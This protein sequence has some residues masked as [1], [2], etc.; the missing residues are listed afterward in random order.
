MIGE[1]GNRMIYIYISCC[2]FFF[3]LMKMAKKKPKLFCGGGGGD[4]RV[5]ELVGPE[6]WW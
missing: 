5:R 2:F 3:L 4:L 6:W 1:A